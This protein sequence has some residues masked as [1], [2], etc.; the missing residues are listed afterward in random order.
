M[1]IY[2]RRFYYEKLLDAKKT[3]KKKM[4]EHNKKIKSP[5]FKKPS[6]SR[7]K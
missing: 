4:D 7:F 3:E 6:N 5:S 1:P 2:L